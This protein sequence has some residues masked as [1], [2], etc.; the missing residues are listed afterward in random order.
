MWS[1]ELLGVVLGGGLAIAGGVGGQLLT[2]Y[3]D[4]RRERRVLIRERGE[5]LVTALYRH[6]A[7]LEEKRVVVLFRHQSVYFPE[8]SKYMVQLMT[9]DMHMTTV[10]WAAAHRTDEGYE[11][12]AEDRGHEALYEYVRGVSQRF[13]VV[14]GCH[15][16]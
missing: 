2:H 12:L 6:K 4:Q 9:A 11:R 8:L 13:R 14:R 10:H 3:L 1:P 15:A 7:W 16:T 5:L